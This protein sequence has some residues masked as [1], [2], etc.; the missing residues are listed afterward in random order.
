MKKNIL[1]LVLSL[2]FIPSLSA[3]G[4]PESYYEISNVKKQK[5]V[6][7]NHLYTLIEYE[8]VR[9]LKDRE[10]IKNT[11]SKNIFQ[12]NY[13]S[14]DFPKLLKLKKKYKIKSI[15]SLDEFLKRIDIVPPSLALAQAAVES[16][17]GKSRFVKEANNIFGHWTYGEKGIIPQNRNEDAKHKIRIFS[18]LQTSIRAYMLNLN[19]NR[20]YHLFR[21][22]RAKLRET[23]LAPTGMEL[24]QTMKNYS[25]IGNKYLEILTN[26]INKQK[27]SKFDSKFF[28]KLNQNI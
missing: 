27:L 3:A 17:W 8:N 11:L 4:F 22:K 25:G 23:N 7:L 26:L 1:L 10:I 13:Q 21:S 19:S 24:S 9:I 6:F 5:E 20:A 16:G 12:I 18:S 14:K 15:H 28:N 2:Y